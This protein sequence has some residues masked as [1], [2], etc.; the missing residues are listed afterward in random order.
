LTIP[1]RPHT[2]H[3]VVPPPTISFLIG[4]LLAS[5]TNPNLVWDE[6]SHQI[7]IAEVEMIAMTSSLLGYYPLRAGWLFTF[8]GAGTALNGLKVALGKGYP[9]VYGVWRSRGCCHFI[10]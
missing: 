4:G 5:L 3:N 8:S 1:G 6:Y 2:Q 9:W 7:A 10:Q